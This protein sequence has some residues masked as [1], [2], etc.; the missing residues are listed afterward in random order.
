M[1]PTPRLRKGPVAAK[2]SPKL[3]IL[4]R[5]VFPPP[6]EGEKQI[7]ELEAVVYA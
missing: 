7:F 3:E 5:V 6:L 2:A 1:E 4:K